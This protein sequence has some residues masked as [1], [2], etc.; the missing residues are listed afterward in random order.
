MYLLC[1][2]FS[3]VIVLWS[4]FRREMIFEL[5]VGFLVL[6]IILGVVLYNHVKVLKGHPGVL[7][8]PIFGNLYYFYRTLFLYDFNGETYLF[9][10][11]YKKNIDNVSYTKIFYYSEVLWRNKQL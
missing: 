1:E 9:T 5:G 10:H 4:V 7:G 6:H 8:F 2:V 11:C 3:F